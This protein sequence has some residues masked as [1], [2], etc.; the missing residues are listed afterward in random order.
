[1]TAQR[2]LSYRQEGRVGLVELTNVEARNSLSRELLTQLRETFLE[3][4]SDDGIRS[5]LLTG[6]GGIFCSG[7]D[8]NWLGRED[9]LGMIKAH[10]FIQDVFIS[11]ERF[12]KPVVAALN[13]TALGAGMILA[14][15]ADY[16]IALK[17][18]RMGLP[19]IKVGMPIFLSGAKIL[20][21]F[22]P[23]GRIQELLIWGEPLDMETARE[24]GLVHHWVESEEELRAQ[25]LDRAARLAEAS[26]IAL[27]ILKRTL[28]AGYE[29]SQSAVLASE[30]DTL[31]YFW[32]TE[33]CKEGIR[34]FFERRPPRFSGK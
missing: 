13:G 12:T 6:S 1:M 15:L 22:L 29:S 32:T 25:A 2:L 34:S 20:Q 28:K 16:R 14:L 19:E 30:M 4:D 26:P 3:I 27:K 24:W 10:Q 9:S 31:G 11:L 21:K 17:T 18:A 33:D 23:L 5:V 8:L 7:M